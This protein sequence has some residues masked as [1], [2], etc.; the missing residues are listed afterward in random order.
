MLLA[1]PAVLAQTADRALHGKPQAPR[2]LKHFHWGALE[3][4]AIDATHLEPECDIGIVNV[5]GAL[6]HAARTPEVLL[7]LLPGSILQ[8]HNT[9]DATCQPTPLL[10]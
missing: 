6:P 8:A 5:N 7:G 1:A 3:P 10:L 9:P 4:A 2:C